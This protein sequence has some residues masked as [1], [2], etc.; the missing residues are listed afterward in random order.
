MKSDRAVY[1]LNG[2][3][4][5]LSIALAH[6]MSPSTVKS[7]LYAGCTIEEAVQP[8]DRRTRNTGIP[9]YEW[10][11]VQGIKNIA[12]LVGVTE[13]TIY[14]HLRRTK[15]IDSA[16]LSVIANRNSRA[17]AKLQKQN[18]SVDDSAEKV[19]SIKQPLLSSA[20]RT[21]L[22]ISNAEHTQP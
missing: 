20:W 3:R 5:I 22:G 19:I 13:P 10:G 14:A 11:G 1:E 6:D 8:G 12:E 7:R 18:T 9:I 17:L 21:A 4:G 16:V 2:V 15:D